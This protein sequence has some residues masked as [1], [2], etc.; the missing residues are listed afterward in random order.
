MKSAAAVEAL[1]RKSRNPAIVGAIK[2]I[3][4][5]TNLLALNAAIEG[6]GPANRPRALRWSLT[7]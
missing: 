1:G 5:Q 4:D 3:A 6:P 2:D 7:R